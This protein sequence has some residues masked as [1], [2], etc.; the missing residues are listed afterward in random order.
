MKLLLGGFAVALA[1]VF[2][3]YA[4]SIMDRAA[5]GEFDCKSAACT[6]FEHQYANAV[7][8]VEMTNAGLQL[9]WIQQQMGEK[10]VYITPI[11]KRI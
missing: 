8:D 4:L 5:A 10:P 9:E 11:P 7:D 2:S 1:T 3:F 6:A